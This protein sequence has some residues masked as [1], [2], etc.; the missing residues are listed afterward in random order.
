M[1][2]E[3][4]SDLDSVGRD[5]DDVDGI[6]RRLTI[7]ES[8]IAELAYELRTRRVEVVDDSDQVRLSAELIDGVLETRIDLPSSTPGRRTGL[9]LFAVP[10]EQELCAG[11]G[12]QLWANG[13]IVNELAWWADHEADHSQEMAREQDAPI[14]RQ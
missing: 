11:F 9:L 10:E 13:N 2:A 7:L 5:G 6:G 14:P 4:V 8:R 3:T 1:E 12:L